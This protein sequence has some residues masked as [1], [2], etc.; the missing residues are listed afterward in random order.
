MG[1]GF[2]RPGRVIEA[3]VSVFRALALSRLIFGSSGMTVKAPDILCHRCAK[4]S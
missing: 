4:A 1:A 2:S 3:I